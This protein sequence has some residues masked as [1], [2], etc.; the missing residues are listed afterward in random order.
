M[1]IYLFKG[2][3]FNYMRKEVA[4][5]NNNNKNNNKTTYFSSFCFFIIK[6]IIIIINIECIS[7]KIW[8]LD[9]N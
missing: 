7:G 5:D 4:V 1:Q 6:I 3:K 2:P 9:F 8:L